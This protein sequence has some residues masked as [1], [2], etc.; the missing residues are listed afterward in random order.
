MIFTVDRRTPRRWPAAGYSFIQSRRIAHFEA[1]ICQQADCVIAVSDE[2]AAILSHLRPDRSVPVITNGIFVDD[3]TTAAEQ[4]D[5]GDYALVFTGK[6]DYRPNVDAMLWFADAVLP[7][8][9]RIVP[10]TRLVIVGQK[11]HPR[12]DSL[13]ARPGVEITGWVRDVKPFL[14]SASVYIAPLRMGSGTRLKLLEAMAAGCAVVA[15]PAAS[16]GMQAAPPDVM[17]ITDQPDQ[18]AA[19]II[20]LLQHPAQRQAL[21]SAA[22]S[23]VKTHYDWPVLI[24]RLLAVYRDMGLE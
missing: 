20:N 12:L 5:L 21:G 17:I 19:A 6:M 4:L 16:S 24:P 23:Y 14:Y 3:Y 7:D 22:R 1:A 13:R 8:I 18:M 15:T 10:Q 11:P 2:D 9:Q